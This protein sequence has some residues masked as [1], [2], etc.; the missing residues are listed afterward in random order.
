MNRY[1]AL[2]DRRGVVQRVLHSF[3]IGIVNEGQN[4]RQLFEE[5]TELDDVLR[6]EMEGC[7][8][9]RLKMRTQGSPC[10]C[11]TIAVINTQLLILAYGLEDTVQ[12]SQL[13][14]MAL[15]AALDVQK[16][17]I[18]EEY[19]AGY[20]EIQKLNSQLINYQRTLAKANVRLQGLLE[21]ARQAKC[22]IEVLE[23]DA[24]TGLYTEKAF[25]ERAA[26]ILKSHPEQDF[27]IVAVDIEQFKIVN[28]TFG[29][30]AGD[31]LLLD[32]SVSL[33]G[34]LA[35]GGV[36]L[37]TRARADTFFAL[38]PQ[39]AEL[40]AD[41]DQ[42]LTYFQEHYPL[43][44]R[45]QIKAGIY[46]VI[47]RGLAVARMCDRA[48]LAASSIKGNYGRGIAQYDKQM[49]E[50]M[51][52]EQKIVNSMVESLEQE[53]FLVYLQPK[54]EVETGR[55]VGA[56]A[57]IRWNHPEFGMI[58]PGDFI[59][60]FERNGF[61]Y[62]VDVFVWEKVCAMQSAWHA[63]GRDGMP[64]S[65]NVSRADLYHEDLPETLT[66]L[67]Q[68]YGL[69]PEQVPLEITESAYVKDAA[70]LLNVIKR[71]KQAGFI[72]EMDDFGS[73]Y[74]ALNTLY[75]LPID[76][77]KLDLRFLNHA[78]NEVRSQSVMQLVIDLAKALDLAVIAE[79]VETE[80][81]A[82]LL[83]NMDCTCAQGYL[84]GRPMPEKDFLQYWQEK[85]MLF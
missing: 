43:P 64:I 84:Y 21:E 49:H 81:Q 20:Y 45:L 1:I 14:E 39:C 16:G 31:R 68:K 63:S 29:T 80:G 41:L 76:V 25:Y 17:S 8:S 18:S 71:L 33:M 6:E 30:E 73:G 28:D 36:T 56:E 54:V 5:S 7:L 3:P 44:M 85:A 10:V 34:V 78:E 50:K 12:F 62:A 60:V 59:P 61:I 52:L 38:L 22:T 79:G 75:E 32:L 48:L 82:L 4:I 65:V 47:E 13:V 19:G 55:I 46:P 72:I 57:L 27:A 9:L 51:L 40:Y 42:G 69:T 70:Q 35:S 53:D 23:R 67:I 83:K 26:A 11:V 77:M 2:C 74:S 58:P 15:A 24:L 37:L 66:R